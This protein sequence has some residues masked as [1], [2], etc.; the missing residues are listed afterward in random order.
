MWYKSESTVRPEQVDNT[1]SKIYVYVR[2]NI[3][4]TTREDETIGNEV[5]FEFDECKIPKDIY[6]IFKSQ[7]E[8]NDRLDEIEEVIAEI[9]GGVI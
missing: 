5:V 7:L 1:S 4:E 8:A 2:K 3:V 9:V 6:E